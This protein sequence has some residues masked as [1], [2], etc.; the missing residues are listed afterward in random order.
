MTELFGPVLGLMRADHLHHAIE[1][2]NAVP[3]GLTSGLQSLDD[4]EQTKWIDEIEAG[5]LYINRGTT[6][7]IVR[8]QPFGGCKASSIGAGAKAGGP[9]YLR[10]FMYAEQ[11]GLPQE[12]YPINDAV[13]HLTSFLDRLDL[14]A[15]QLGIWT[16]SCANYSYWWRR[17]KQDRDPS[18][19]VGQ[20]NFFRYL[21]RKNIV[22]RLQ[23][24]SNPLDVLRVCAAVH[25][26]GAK[27]EISCPTEQGSFNWPELTS[28]LPLIEESEEQ[29]LHRL[30]EGGIA[31]VRLVDPAS[32]AI[33]RAAAEFAV[34]VIDDPVLIN[35]R[36]ELLHY[37]REVALSI[38][39][40][41]YGNLGLREGELRKPIL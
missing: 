5:N 21:P 37:L 30:K 25:T 22:L 33:L 8:R 20:D 39:Y 7:A 17:M 38:D 18:K 6:G 41:R 40:H 13:N 31:R 1:L 2:A 34:Y 12:K 29:F 28:S 32:E 3:Y 14:T 24:K 26:C 4:R 35:G 11:T 9:N 15:E 16:A 19:I 27:V 36:L 23:K 10:E